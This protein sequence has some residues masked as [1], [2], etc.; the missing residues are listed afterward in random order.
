[1]SPVWDRYE[2]F[3]AWAKANGYGPGHVLRRRDTAADYGPSNCYFEPRR[4]DKTRTVGVLVPLTAAEHE[5]LTARARAAGIPV[6]RLIRQAIGLDV[7]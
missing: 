6:R 3:A 4:P 5:A 2:D 1:M 7:P